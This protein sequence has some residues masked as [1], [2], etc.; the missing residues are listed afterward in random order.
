MYAE[1]W[2]QSC[3][4]GGTQGAQVHVR[5]KVGVGESWYLPTGDWL[6]RERLAVGMD[7]GLGAAERRALPSGSGV[8]VWD[9]RDL[10]RLPWEPG[11]EPRPPAE[12]KVRVKPT[13]PANQRYREN[14]RQLKNYTNGLQIIAVYG[15]VQIMILNRQTQTVQ[16]RESEKA[17]HNVYRYKQGI[18]PARLDNV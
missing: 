3:V 10:P 4:L 6:P 7:S 13:T 16:C 5:G 1:L 8:F 18:T 2:L 17:L 11:E 14:C 9:R 12:R 15:E